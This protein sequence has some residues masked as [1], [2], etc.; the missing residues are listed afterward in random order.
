MNHETVELVVGSIVTSE[1][2][3]PFAMQ[4]STGT[5]EL[6][7]YDPQ[8]AGP[9]LDDEQQRKIVSRLRE[10]IDFP[11]QEFR[12][13]EYLCG[14]CGE[15]VQATKDQWSLYICLYCSLDRDSELW[16]Y[17]QGDNAS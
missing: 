12:L 9:S 3:R 6:D 11:V 13:G 16:E 4:L 14:I 5:V 15:W 2:A 17:Y 8:P 1:G 7:V 10:G